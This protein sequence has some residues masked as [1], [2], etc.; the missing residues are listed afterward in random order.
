MDIVQR[1]TEILL[2][3]KQVTILQEDIQFFRSDDNHNPPSNFGPW[4][5]FPILLSY[6]GIVYLGL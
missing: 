5:P 4:H 6:Q 1:E 2:F 3:L